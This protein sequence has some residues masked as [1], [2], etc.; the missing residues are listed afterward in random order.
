M[1]IEHTINLALS[2]ILL[3][4]LVGTILGRY[5]PSKDSK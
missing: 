4:A 3:G 5:M 1:T 2:S